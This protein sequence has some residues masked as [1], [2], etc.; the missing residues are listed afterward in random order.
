MLKLVLTPNEIYHMEYQVK[1]G[2]N[3]GLCIIEVSGT[4]KRPEDS[5]TLQDLAKQINHEEGCSLFCFDFTNAEVIGSTMDIYT[6]GNFEHDPGYE[7]TD[8]RF[9]F[10]Y[11][12]ITRDHQFLQTVATNLGYQLQT[13]TE[14]DKAIAWLQKGAGETR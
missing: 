4:Y 7:Q 6:A 2:A 13:F 5:F 9:A 14:I 10:V 12:K 11:D 1:R 3:K 8:H